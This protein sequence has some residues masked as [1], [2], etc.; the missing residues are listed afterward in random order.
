[1]VV[2]RIMIFEELKNYKL[3]LQDFYKTFE[4]KMHLGVFEKYY[5]KK[6]YD[7][8]IRNEARADFLECNRIRLEIKEKTELFEAAISRVEID[9]TIL[10]P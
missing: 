7:Q 9:E 4:E 1:M 3:N 8:L 10:K 6:I 5:I 2:F